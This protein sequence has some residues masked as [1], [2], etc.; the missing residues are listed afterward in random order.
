MFEPFHFSLFFSVF[1]YVSLLVYCPL[2]I[3]FRFSFY[4]L[5]CYAFYAWSNLIY[6]LPLLVH[7]TSRAFLSNSLPDSLES[8]LYLLNASPTVSLSFLVLFHCFHMPYILPFVVLKN[9]SQS[10][11]TVLNHKS[12]KRLF[13][14]SVYLVFSS[15]S[16]FQ[17]FSYFAL[18]LVSLQNMNY[19]SMLPTLA[20]VSQK[21][22][23]I[24][25]L[26]R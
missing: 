11:V 20:I 10:S 15:F 8:F 16:F 25:S 13:I 4:S 26:F 14:V 24:V 23:I 19:L 21:N 3:K 1:L 9:C 22:G 17:S 2:I 7:L 18:L 6:M 12:E 5:L